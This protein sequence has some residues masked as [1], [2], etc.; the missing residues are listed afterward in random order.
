MKNK[1]TAGP[2]NQ[3]VRHGL[4][5]DVDSCPYCDREQYENKFKYE[6]LRNA[7]DKYRNYISDLNGTIEYL[8]KEINILKQAL[9]KA[10]GE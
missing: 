8:Y 2:F 7:E 6:V 3:C 10:R 5:Y 1:F 9:A 4:K